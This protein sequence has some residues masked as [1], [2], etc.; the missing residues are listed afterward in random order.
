MVEN[1]ISGRRTKQI[2]V[3]HYFTR[4]L[5]E[6]RGLSVRFTQSYSQLEGIVKNRVLL[7]N[8]SE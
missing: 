2:D 3:R 6:C 5:V 4:E 7:M 8:L 1:P